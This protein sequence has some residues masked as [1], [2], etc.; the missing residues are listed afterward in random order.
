MDAVVEL[1]WAGQMILVGECGQGD[2]GCQSVEFS[3]HFTYTY[4]DN[5]PESLTD[6]GDLEIRD[7][8]G[9]S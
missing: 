1:R 6:L 8:Q 7:I 3:D 2:V 5:P 9:N 4:P